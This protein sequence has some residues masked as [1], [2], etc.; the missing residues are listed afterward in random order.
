MVTGCTFRP[1]TAFYTDICHIHVK[2]KCKAERF[3]ETVNIF[4]HHKIDIVPFYSPHHA[5]KHAGTGQS[6]NLRS[7]KRSNRIVVNEISKISK[8]SKQLR[9]FALSNIKYLKA[10]SN[11]NCFEC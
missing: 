2:C 9:C 1:F 3:A 7:S 4:A 6:L 11:I 10:V 5:A 8:I